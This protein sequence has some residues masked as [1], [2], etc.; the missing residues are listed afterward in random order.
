MTV[1]DAMVHRMIILLLFLF[2]LCRKYLDSLKYACSID[3]KSDSPIG[4]QI[5]KGSV[6]S[7]YFGAF[8]IK[9]IRD[10]IE[11]K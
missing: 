4:R 8:L 3:T 5:S 10:N 7:K 11:I 2:F 9:L 6:T 1:K